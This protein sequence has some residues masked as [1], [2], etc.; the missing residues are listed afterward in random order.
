MA[1]QID[2]LFV[3]LGLEK[4]DKQFKDAERSFDSL[5]TSALQF[6]AV[7]GAGFGLNELTFGFA[8]TINEANKLSEVFEGLQVTP[9]FVSQLEGAFRLIDED[10]SEAAATIQSMADLIEGTDWGEISDQAFARGFDPSAILGARNMAEAM[11]ALNDQ[12]RAM[13]DPEQARRLASALG[14]SDAQ[15]RLFRQ[16]NIGG[17]MAEASRLRPLTAGQSGA[18]SEFQEGFNRLSLSVEGLSRSISETFVGDLG[19]NMSDLAEIMAE[20]RDAITEFVDGALPYLKNAAAG[21]GVLVAIQTARAGLGILQKIPG[22]A[23]AAAGAGVLVGEI[24]DAY[25]PERSEEMTRKR[26]VDQLK[27]RLE[28]LNEQIGIGEEGGAREDAVEALRREREEV[29]KMI[30]DRGGDLSMGPDSMT[31]GG[32]SVSYSFNI[33]ARG[34]ADPQATEVAV[35]RAIDSAIDRMTQNTVRDFAEPIV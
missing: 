24:I 1:E 16:T 35:G 9:Q 21:I 8:R 4:D 13:D 2:D 3:R 18:A 28:R 32:G 29:R 19:Q 26:N 25:D 33:D 7:I 14:L 31:P 10:A 30:R 27:N 6:G 20:N 17:Q 22:A 12:I 5:K 11:G 34:A 23:L 15:F